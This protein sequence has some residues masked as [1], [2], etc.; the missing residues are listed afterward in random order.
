MLKNI[1][2]AILI[3]C[4]TALSVGAAFAA[5]GASNED[6]LR[7]RELSKSV[8][9]FAFDLYKEIAKEE[10]GSIFFSPLSISMALALAYEGAAGETRE[11]MRR[12]LHYDDNVGKQFRAYLNILNN[13]TKE[14]GELIL[15]SAVWPDST[16]KLRKKYIHDITKYYSSEISQLNFS[17]SQQ[18]ADEINI[19]TN[20][21][22]RGKIQTIVS[23]RDIGNSALVLTNAAYFKGE[24]RDKFNEQLTK[25][26]EFFTSPKEV[27][28]IPFMNK[29][30]TLAY[31]EDDTLQC[32]KLPFKNN[33]YSLAVILP[34]KWEY[35]ELITKTLNLK[36]F[37][38][39]VSQL[40]SEKVNLYLPKYSETKRY[41]KISKY[42]SSLGMKRALGNLAD[43]RN[44]MESPSRDRLYIQNIIHKSTFDIDE[45]YTEASAATAVGM[46]FTSTSL[47]RDHYIEFNA[48]RPFLYFILDDNS[49]IL[50]IGRYCE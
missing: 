32:I 27:K 3:F 45:A 33:L 39:I 26:K 42:L 21:Q 20:K 10:K 29:K 8:N 41:T 44:I 22:T 38:T 36:K 12:V 34:S 35:Q 46:T 14:S 28:K 9:A 47:K 11:E 37:S 4:L 5:D 24:W 1:G 25:E 19:W 48:N 17:Q 6:L 15:A 43:F 18:S 7:A 30:G 49:M 40:K 50:F 16:L 23:P 31:Y 13:T 2:P